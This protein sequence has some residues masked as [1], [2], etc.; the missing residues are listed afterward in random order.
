MIL[1]P[2]LLAL[3]LM[4]SVVAAAS[5]PMAEA[6]ATVDQV[7]EILKNPQYKSV[8]A[9][10]RQML[11]AVIA[12]HFD[13]NDMSR[14]ALG[15]HWRGL[16]DAQRREFVGLFT[17]LLEAAYLSRIENYSGQTVAFLRESQDGPGYSE[18]Y[19]NIVEKDAQP[20]S[21]NYR[22]KQTDSGWKVYDVL[23]DG[24]SLVANYRNQFNRVINDEGYESLVGRIKMKADQASA[25]T[26]GS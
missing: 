19:T 18:V 8:P 10:R 23:V 11:R 14:S 16:S 26:S 24:I 22:M 13:F 3:V 17:S 5:D 20:I 12:S 2:A 9:Q 25:E 15:F 7:L 21:V 4:V 1:W 6:K